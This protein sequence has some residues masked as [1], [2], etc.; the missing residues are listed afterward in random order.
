M[1][2]DAHYAQTYIRMDGPGIALQ[3]SHHSIPL[4]HILQIDDLLLDIR[5]RLPLP[6]VLPILR[7]RLAAHTAAA[8][9]AASLV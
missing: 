2:C 6:F 9:A 5:L 4:A 8:A 3:P 1:R 7:A